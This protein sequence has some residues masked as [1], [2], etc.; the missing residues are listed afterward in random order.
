MSLADELKKARVL[1]AEVAEAL[2]TSPSTV[3]RWFVGQHFPSGKHLPELLAFLNRPDV[4]ARLG[5]T[6]PIGI[7]ELASLGGREALPPDSSPAAP[8]PAR[9][10]RGR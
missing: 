7:D 2:G 10:R 9:R 5:R 8:S 3:N 1:Q 6:A 4:L